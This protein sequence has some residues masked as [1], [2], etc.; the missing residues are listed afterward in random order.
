M[1]QSFRRAVRNSGVS[2]GFTWHDLRHFYASALIEAG[3]S[4]KT[5]Q[6]RMGHAN[7]ATTLRIYTHLWP[8][9]DAR[10]RSAIDAIFAADNNFYPYP[11]P[12][13]ER[14]CSRPQTGHRR[15]GGGGLREEPPPIRVFLG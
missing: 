15:D 2:K 1:G 3:A 4:V 10:T 8:D 14:G 11:V 9:Q 5:V 13:V 7:A 12:A 6:H